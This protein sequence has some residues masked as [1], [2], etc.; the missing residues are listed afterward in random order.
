MDRKTRMNLVVNKLMTINV[1]RLYVARKYGG[2][3]KGGKEQ[4]GC[5]E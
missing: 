5:C 3:G 1:D 2:K 4:S